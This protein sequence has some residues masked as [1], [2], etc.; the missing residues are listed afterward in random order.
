MKTFVRFC[1]SVIVGLLWVLCFAP[2]VS[3]ANQYKNFRVAVYIPVG[4]VERMQDPQ[5]LESSWAT[6]S[7]QVKIDKVYIETYRS[8]HIADERLIEQVKKFFLAHGV[9]VAGGMALT[10]NDAGQFESFCYTDPADREYVKNISAM[11]ARHFDEIILDDFFFVTTKRDSDIAAKGSR[12]WTQ[13][14]LELMDEV[15][16]DLVI[17]PVKAANPKAKIIIKFPNW[18][19]HFQGLGFDLENEPKL[20]DGIYTGTETRESSITDQNLQQYESYEV[21]RYFENI[22][23]GGNGGGWVDTYDLLFVDRYAEQLWDTMFAKAAEI[24]L[25]NWADLLRPVNPG[26]RDAWKD[27]HTSF[28][29][30]HMQA[31]RASGGSSTAAMARVAGYSLDQVDPFLN[32][33]GKPIGLKSYKPYNS[34]GED[35]LHNHLGMIGIPVDLY[36]Y[37][38]TDAEMVLLTE[39]AKFDPEIV[40][41]MKTQLQSGK[42]VVITSGLLRALQGKG[43]ED[44]VELQYTDHKVAVHDYMNAFGAGSGSKLGSAQTKGILF[45]EIRFLTND[46]WVLVRGMANDNG[47]PILLMNHYSKGTIYVLSV[48][49]NFTDLYEMPAEVLN[50]IKSYLLQDFP[51]RL[52][53]PSKVSLFAYDN[54]TFIV[55]SFRSEQTSATVLLT[56]GFSKLK[57]LVTGEVIEAQQAAETQGQSR[58]RGPGA[59]NRATFQVTLK[60]HSYLVFSAEK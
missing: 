60:P 28:D 26:A 48:P 25:F 17:G 7:S 42:S 38:P 54:N 16:K 33:L 46:S 35:F 8:R 15:A 27:Q 5:W 55:E 47:F 32:L 36:P 45:P 34:T 2:N 58:R 21:L 59:A 44:I 9:Q 6:L 4:A 18:Y 13:F 31:Y 23:P 1:V 51:V 43:I 14:R 22:K 39:S 11:T 12:S 50:T 57:N 10:G 52:D 3:Q 19:E 29:Y 40:A 41:K 56:G 37:F 24:T 30:D 49:E 20:F 53:A